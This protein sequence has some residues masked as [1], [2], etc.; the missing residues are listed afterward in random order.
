MTNFL[1][2]KA[3]LKWL[4]FQDGS[5]RVGLHYLAVENDYPDINKNVQMPY[6]TGQ[7]QN[8]TNAIMH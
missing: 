5:I 3:Y 6:S 4:I 7:S 1:A 2:E 8:S